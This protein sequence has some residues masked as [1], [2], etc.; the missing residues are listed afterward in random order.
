MGLLAGSMLLINAARLLND[1]S[2]KDRAKG[3]VVVSRD[4]GR[5]RTR[6][7]IECSESLPSDA[8]S[9]GDKRKKSNAIE[10]FLSVQVNNPPFVAQKLLERY[11][12]RSD[13]GEW[14]SLNK[15]QLQD[16]EE[17]VVLI[18]AASG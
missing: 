9:A 8:E 14:F 16:L 11:A 18:Y 15:K 1:L 12:N 7:R 10:T 4:K 3:Y 5:L 2:K 13:L 6:Y 17:I